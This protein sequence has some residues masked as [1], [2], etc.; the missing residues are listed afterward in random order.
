MTPEQTTEQQV[1]EVD[2]RWRGNRTWRVRVGEGELTLHSEELASL[3]SKGLLALMHQPGAP[4][5]VREP[6]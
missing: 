6:S 5:E 2:I 1:R 3:C 4:G